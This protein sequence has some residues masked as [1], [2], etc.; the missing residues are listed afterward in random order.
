MSVKRDWDELFA[1]S[2][3]EALIE[4]KK[5]LHNKDY[6]E[7]DRG[8][9][10]LIEYTVHEVEDELYEELKKLMKYVLLA[11]IKPEAIDNS[12]LLTIE[13]TRNEIEYIRQEN[14][15]I[16]DAFIMNI[17]N[18]TFDIVKNS[19]EDDLK[20]SCEIETLLWD[21]VFNKQFEWVE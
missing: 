2:S 1:T 21:E 10:K 12:L 20:M 9:D 15:F 16:D 11:I 7:V 4:L 17:W 6:E 8:I 5:Y 19:I 13:T 18:D 3:Y 14:T